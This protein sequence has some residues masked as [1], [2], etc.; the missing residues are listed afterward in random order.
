[1]AGGLF[2]PCVE[3]VKQPF[4]SDALQA[5]CFFRIFVDER[6]FGDDAF[7]EALFQ[8]VDCAVEALFFFVAKERRQGARLEVFARDAEEAD[9]ALDA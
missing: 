8:C 9:A 7:A 5:L 2:S 1:M 4:Q 3:S 6:R